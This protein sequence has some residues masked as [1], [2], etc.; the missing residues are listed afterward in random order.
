MRDFVAILCAREDSIYKSLPGCDV[1]DIDRDAI[2]FSGGLPVIAHPPCRSWGRLRKFSKPRPG[3]RDL[4]RFCVRAVQMCGGVLEH[5][6]ASSLWAD[7]N[8]PRPGEVPDEF[9]GYSLQVSQFWFGHRAEKSTWLYICGVDR[10]LIPPAPLRFDQP[11]HVVAQCT[12]SVQKRPELP[13]AEREATPPGFAAFLLNIVDLVSKQTDKNCHKN[14]FAGLAVLV[15]PPLSL[16][17]ET[18][19]AT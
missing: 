8:L 10:S 16:T 19:Y 1:Y 7:M 12:K 2:S 6:T 9:G 4:A 18:F 13:R 5:P 11:T 3:E 14:G 15:T 17:H